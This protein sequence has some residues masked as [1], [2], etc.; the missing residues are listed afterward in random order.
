MPLTNNEMDS[1]SFIG[2]AVPILLVIA[3]LLLCL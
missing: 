1:Y 2:C 3:A